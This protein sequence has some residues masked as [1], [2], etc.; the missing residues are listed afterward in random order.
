MASAATAELLDAAANFLWSDSL[1]A[2][3][4][5]F[6]KQHAHEFIGATCSGEQRLEYQDLFLRYQDLCAVSADLDPSTP[7]SSADTLIVTFLVQMSMRSRALSLVKGAR[8]TH[9]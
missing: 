8:W 9:L 7:D 6:I 1:Q 5:A 2:S 3:A 4:D